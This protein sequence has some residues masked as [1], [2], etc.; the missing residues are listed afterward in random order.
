MRDYRKR[1]GINLGYNSP[2]FVCDECKCV[3]NSVH[4]FYWDVYSRKFKDASKN[5]KVLCSECTPSEY[6]D[7]TK[8]GKGKWHG[9]F[10]KR[11]W[12]GMYDVANR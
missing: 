1:K 8:T 6:A 2:M 9:L 7:G 3:D 12:D 10:P 5:G 11:K 4:G